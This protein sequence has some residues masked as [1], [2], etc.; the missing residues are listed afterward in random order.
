MGKVNIEF[1]Y[2]TVADIK[3][4]K[5]LGFEDPKGILNVMS[6]DVKAALLANP[7][8]LSENDVCQIIALDGKKVV[9]SE[10]S[11]PNKYVVNGEIKFCR[12]AST[13]FSDE[14]YRKHAVGT[15][16]MI[17]AT[18]ITSK[19]DSIVAGISQMAYPLYKAMRYTCFS[20]QRFVFLNKSRVAV[21]YMLKQ[22]SLLTKIISQIMDILL[23]FYRFFVFGGNRLRMRKYSIEIVSEVPQEVEDIARGDNQRYMELHDKNWFEWNLNYSF[24]PNGKKNKYLAVIKDKDDKIVAFFLN[25]ITFY[26][27]AS[28]RGFK[29][30]FLGTVTEWGIRKGESLSEFDVQMTAIRYMPK[31]IDGAEVATTAKDVVKDFK[32]HLLFPMGE[33]NIAV[34][35]QSFKEKAMKDINNWRIRLAAGDTLLN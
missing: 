33:A 22:N 16:L 14:A 9:G 13:L 18:T 8:L 15:D 35:I 2:R 6:E 20:F 3:A 28:S 19:Q 26:K 17:N 32:Y 23:V 24:K 5:D 34:Y 25:K 21:E 30:I 10:L 4:N 12:G 1:Y 11:F 31:D 27:Q 29:N 7:S